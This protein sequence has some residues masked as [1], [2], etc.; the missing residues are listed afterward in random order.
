MAKAKSN[1]TALEKAIKEKQAELEKIREEKKACKDD[2]TSLVAYEKKDQRVAGELKALEKAF[3]AASYKP[4]PPT[5]KAEL[6]QGLEKYKQEWKDRINKINAEIDDNENEQ[7]ELE[8]LLGKA[9]VEAETGKT[10]ELSNR[11]DEVK[12]AKGHLLEMLARAESIPVYPQGAIREE[13][14]KICQALLPE[15][16]NR[17]SEVATFADAYIE[18]TN[19]LLT[20]RDTIQDVRKELEQIEGTQFSPFFTVGRNADDLMIDKPYAAKLQNMF[21][22]TFRRQI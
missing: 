21:I 5:D 2:V 10:I 11:L 9:A 19:A 4:E 14:D 3:E 17:L 13:W 7:K 20:M 6:M 22:S 16:E 12:I 15:W 1:I 8:A 18:S